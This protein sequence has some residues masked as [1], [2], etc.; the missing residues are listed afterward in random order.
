MK[1]YY[2]FKFLDDE[3]NE[4]LRKLAASSGVNHRIDSDGT[5]HYSADDVDL[6]ENELL[7]TIRSSVFPSWQIIN[8]PAE[9]ANSYKDYMLIHNVKFKEELL[10]GQLRFLLARNHRPHH[11]K[12]RDP[13]GRI[14]RL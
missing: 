2:N 8:C 14:Q 9:W 6:V 12:L 5:L 7:R 1:S 13:K 3:L 11:W 10:D 4:R